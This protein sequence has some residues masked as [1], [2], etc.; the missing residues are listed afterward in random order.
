VE[1]NNNNDLQHQPPTTT[2]HNNHHNNRPQLQPPAPTTND[3]IRPQLRPPTP[4][5][6]DNVRQH[7]PINHQSTSTVQEKCEWSDVR[8]IYKRFFGRKNFSTKNL[9][10][11]TTFG[12]KVL[13]K[14]KIRPTNMVHDSRGHR[15]GTV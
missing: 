14:K 11:E 4:T 7:Q 12:R 1:T 5:T 6:N 9:L 3:N 8:V 13:P 2:A 15:H 10:A